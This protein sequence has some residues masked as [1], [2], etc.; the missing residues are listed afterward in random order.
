MA[1][2]A[3][4]DVLNSDAGTAAIACSLS[5]QFRSGGPRGW[6]GLYAAHYTGGNLFVPVL[7]LGCGSVRPERD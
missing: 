3:V 1:L 6:T 5:I 2:R 7:H 4:D